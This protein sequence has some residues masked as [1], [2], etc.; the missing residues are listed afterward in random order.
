MNPQFDLIF[1]KLGYRL[2]QEREE[3]MDILQE[4]KEIASFINEDTKN[5]RLEANK[6]AKEFEDQ[7][8]NPS[9]LINID[10]MDQRY[11]KKNEMYYLNDTHSE[12]GFKQI[13]ATGAV[14]VD[15]LIKT[16]LIVIEQMYPKISQIYQKNK[17]VDEVWYID[18]QSVAGGNTHMNIIPRI[19]PGFDV[20]GEYDRGERPYSR[21]GI[22]GPGQNPERKSLWSPDALIEI[23]DEFV[24][25]AQAPVYLKNELVGKI[26][27]HYNLA[28]LREDTIAKSHF[29][30][31]LISNQFTLIGMSA[32]A[33]TITHFTEYEKKRW[34]SK[35]AKM[36]Y[37]D[38]VLNLTK[39][40]NNF[41][42]KLKN[43]TPGNSCDCNF[44]GQNY[45][46]VRE[47]IPEV[48]FQL[49]VLL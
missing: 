12:V 26:S 35:K 29:N 9:Y 16:K 20:G 13:V 37:V 48:G 21:F 38:N 31:I 18:M 19:V 8:S 32:S 42:N 28:F 43:L 10:E 22:I 46:V 2:L 44:F 6:L 34:D 39:Q 1:A 17:Y 24:I 5:V 49:L 30:L 14:P 36:E 15:N 40:N 3:K 27:V 25:S 47:D 23:F 11:T 7:F 45:T 4:I 33:K 41:A